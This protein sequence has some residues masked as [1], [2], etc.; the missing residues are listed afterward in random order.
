MS[1]DKTWKVLR[2]IGKQCSKT[3][4]DAGSDF[5]IQCVSLTEKLVND[6]SRNSPRNR[7]KAKKDVLLRW[8]G[9]MFDYLTH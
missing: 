6:A 2:S 8:P 9:L 3:S 5:A 4:T 1:G 7:E